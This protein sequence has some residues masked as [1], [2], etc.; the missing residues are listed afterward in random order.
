MLALR[1]AAAPPLRGLS[2]GAVAVVC[3]G[4][5]GSL[6]VATL[7]GWPLW[8]KG[9]AALVPWL[10]VFFG[11]LVW[12]YQRYR[13]LALFYAVVVTQGG[14]CI[15]HISQMIQIHVLGLSGPAAR[16]IFGALDIETVHFVWNTWVILA[17]AL[18]LTRYRDNR[19]LWLTALL[20]GWHE[21]EH[22]YIFAVYLQ[23]GLSGTPGL[24]SQGGALWG[25]LPITRPDLH[26]LYN[27]IESA[28]LFMAF[29]MQVQT[30]PRRRRRRPLPA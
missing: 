28:P 16:G 9:G 24:L 10:P 11:D 12:I 17:V 4:S 19:W 27:A 13:W 20:A 18:L 25:G 3:M 30:E 5:L 8:A 22:A 29:F 14:H 7:E 26:F 6:A 21:I 23:T 1:D 15:E 2:T